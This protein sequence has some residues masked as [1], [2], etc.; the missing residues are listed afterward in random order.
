MKKIPEG[1]ES[2][3]LGH[4]I[5]NMLGGGTPDRS[6][7]DYWD[8]EIPW[9]TVKDLTSPILAGTS[10]HITCEGLQNS[11]S[12]LIPSGTIIMATRMA[13][14]KAVRFVCDVAINQDLK[15][16]F[17]KKVLAIEFL[18]QWFRWN[19]S[20]FASLGSGSTVAGIRQEVIKMFPILL[21]PLPEQEKIADI[22]GGVDAAINATRR[23][24]EQTRIL[25]RSL[26]Q[27]LLTRGIPGRHKR[28]KPSPLGEIPEEWEVVKLREIAV[29]QTG[30]AKNGKIK[31]GHS[32]KVPYLRVANVQ[33]GYVDLSEMKDIE[34]SEDKL[35]RYLLKRRDVLFNEGGDAD[36]LGRGCV[37]EGQI[38]PCVHQ[39]HVFVVRCGKQLNPY[40]L[41]CQAGSQ[42]GKQF[43]FH[44]SK[45]TTNLA[46]INSS[47]LKEFPVFLP[48]INEQKS[49]IRALDGTDIRIN[50]EIKT[51][52]ILQSVEFALMQA[53]L[54]GD[55]RIPAKALKRK[56]AV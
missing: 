51:I 30:I 48:D 40:F 1:W 17:P 45:Q 56:E 22:L 10:E 12:K 20:N 26:M 24:I 11:S 8:G 16:V 44:S 42:R 3:T 19:E 28:F 38:D 31:N 53:L 15:A 50:N 39:N 14:G 27:Q 43:F 46:S 49:I 25:K 55:T 37:W 36:K 9:A 18:H 33:D 13:V 54:S 2:T 41:A 23:V 52:E 29:I 47:Q 21:P 35:K 5:E 4:Q 32:I 6:N 7:P 34:I